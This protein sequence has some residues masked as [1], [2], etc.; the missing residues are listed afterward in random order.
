LKFELGKIKARSEAVHDYVSAPSKAKDAFDTRSAEYKL[1]TTVMKEL[2]KKAYAYTIVAFSAEWCP[3]CLRNIPVLH[4]IAEATGMGI[5]VF[6]HLMRDAKSNE[7]RWAV[8][9]SPPEVEEFNV[10]K[11]PLIV[12]LNKRG[13]KIGEII[14]NPPTGKTLEQALLDIMK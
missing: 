8:P 14:E 5:R 9:P 7:R 12:V 10:V 13:E 3:D 4:L 1:D 2:K 11:I 6:G